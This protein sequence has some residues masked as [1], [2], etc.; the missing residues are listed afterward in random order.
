[1]LMAGILGPGELMQSANFGGCWWPSNALAIL[2]SERTRGWIRT[3]HAFY[4]G[5]A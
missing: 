2:H 1:M 3:F 5:W 4:Y